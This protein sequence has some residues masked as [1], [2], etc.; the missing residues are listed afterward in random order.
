[1]PVPRNSARE[2][3]SENEHRRGRWQRALGEVNSIRQLKGKRGP[4]DARIVSPRPCGDESLSSLSS[5]LY[6]RKNV[7]FF[8]SI[9][10]VLFSHERHGSDENSREREKG[11]EGRRM[12][13]L[14]RQHPHSH[15]SAMHSAISTTLQIFEYRFEIS[16][17][18]PCKYLVNSCNKDGT[19]WAKLNLSLQ[20]WSGELTFF[21]KKYLI[22]VYMIN[23]DKT[24][25]MINNSWSIR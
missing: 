14:L 3:H 17:P 19:W 10:A 15:S 22:H 12:Q 23:K 2:V 7:L 9:V 21:F 24:V 1:M 20:D 13:M 16:S 8:L 6:L 18:V 25:N 11:G 5:S 4:I